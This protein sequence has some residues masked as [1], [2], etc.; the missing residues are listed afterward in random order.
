MMIRWLSL[1]SMSALNASI[2]EWSAI[3]QGASSYC[4]QSGVDSQS[5]I[6]K[7]VFRVGLTRMISVAQLEMKKMNG[8]ILLLLEAIQ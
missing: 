4:R 6:S 1:K 8:S 7:S 5:S 3:S 2:K